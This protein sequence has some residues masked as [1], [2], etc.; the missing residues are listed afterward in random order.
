MLDGT[1]QENDEFKDHFNSTRNNHNNINFKSNGSDVLTYPRTTSHL[2]K[3]VVVD[4][5]D[6]YLSSVELSSQS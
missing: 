3:I 4:D 5:D 1:P 2:L 6:P